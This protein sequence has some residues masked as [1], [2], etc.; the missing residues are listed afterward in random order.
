MQSS[1]SVVGLLVLL[2]LVGMVLLFAVG[3]VMI[4]VGLLKKKEVGADGEGKC[5][6]CGYIV[7]GLKEMR[8]PECGSDFAEVGIVKGEKKR[9][10]GLIVTGGVLV[11]LP[12]ALFLLMSLFVVGMRTQRTNVAVGAMTQQVWITAN[13]NGAIA[14]VGN[15]MTSV[16]SVMT[17]LD[18]SVDQ[19]IEVNKAGYHTVRVTV[20]AGVFLSGLPLDVQME[21]IKDGE[22]DE[23]Q[24]M[25]ASLGDGRVIF[26]ER[27]E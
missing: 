12:V 23:V 2:L 22:V 6:R 19:V 15:V 27:E 5:G 25:E 10:R 18:M 11:V 1:I 8:C 4:L 24:E 26:V 13:V 16:P 14:K 9:R 20:P 3:A 21:K 7:K 17:S